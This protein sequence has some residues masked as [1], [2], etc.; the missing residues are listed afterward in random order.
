M[1]NSRLGLRV[2]S[3][4]GDVKVLG[5]V[6]TDFLGNAPTNVYVT[7]NS[8]TLRM[9][10]FFVDLVKD[11]FELTAGQT[12]SLM[13]PNRK[14]IGV[15]PGDIFFSQDIDTNYQSGLTWARQTGIRATWNP[16][17]NFHVGRRSGKSATVHRLR[18]GA[19]EQAH[20]AGQRSG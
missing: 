18:S 14:A 20:R 19:F 13:T 5:Y 15:L 9:R 3:M 17:E 11:A 7:S 6:E 4:V 1:Q 8:D 16:N 10:L 12:W 2:D